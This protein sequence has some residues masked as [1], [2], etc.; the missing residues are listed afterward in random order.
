MKWIRK[1]LRIIAFILMIPILYI[2]VA[3]FLTYIS[4]NTSNNKK[5]EIDTH[6]IYLYS[7]GVHLDIAIS[8]D[9]VAEPLRF[10][11]KKGK[12]DKFYAF[13]WGD[14]NFYLNTPQWSDLSFKTAFNALFLKSS[15]LIHVSRHINT[16]NNWVAVPVSDEQLRLINEYISKSFAINDKGNL[17]LLPDQGYGYSD[18]FYKANG[19]YT[20]FNTCNTWVNSALKQSGVKACLWTP[21][22][23]GLLQLHTS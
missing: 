21:F 11:L 12:N 14:E 9:D 22:D 8:I 16:G 4:V 2:L 15:T 20:C 3:L 13:G 10:N 5:Q 6:T 7:N 23:F 1:L 18:N 19:Y 17:L